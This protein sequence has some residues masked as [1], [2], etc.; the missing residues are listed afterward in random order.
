MAESREHQ[1]LVRSLTAHLQRSRVTIVG[2]AARGWPTPPLLGG[3]RPDVLGYYFPGGGAAVAGEAK[4]GPELWGCRGQIED[5]LDVLP[6]LSSRGTGALLVLGVPAPWRVEAEEFAR[7]LPRGRT[8]I[9]VWAP[10]PARL[11]DR[12]ARLTAGG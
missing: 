3:R 4:R 6:A 10:V 2:V 12:V 9:D 8:A 5:L 11:D 7:T 1:R